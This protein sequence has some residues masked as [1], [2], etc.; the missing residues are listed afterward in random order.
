MGALPAQEDRV[1]GRVEDHLDGDGEHV[2]G[3]VV[4]LREEEVVRHLLCWL[5]ILQIYNFAKF[6]KFSC[7][8]LQF[9]FSE[10]FDFRFNFQ[11]VFSLLGDVAADEHPL[12]LEAQAGAQVLQAAEVRGGLP[13]PERVVEVPADLLDSKSG[14]SRSNGELRIK[15]VSFRRLCFSRKMQ[16]QQFETERFSKF[17]KIQFKF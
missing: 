8:N 17:H 6:W 16:T 2:E 15:N 1:A 13:V 3:D 12:E 7:L 4:E 10:I 5:Q 9:S 14:R 11:I